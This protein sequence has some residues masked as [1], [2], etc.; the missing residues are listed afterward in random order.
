MWAEKSDIPHILADLRKRLETN[1]KASSLF[2]TQ[3]F[4]GHIEQAYATM[5]EVHASG[6]APHPF[7]V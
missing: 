6:A 1:R 7:A 2:D 5:W 4:R 3:R